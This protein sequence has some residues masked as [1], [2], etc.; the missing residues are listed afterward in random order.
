[1]ELLNQGAII[2]ILLVAG[3]LALV[4]GFAILTRYR[5][6]IQREMRRVSVAEHASNDNNARRQ[7]SAQL[8]YRVENLDPTL[9]GPH[10]PGAPA[11]P[12]PSL[13]CGAIYAAAGIAFGI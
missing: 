13:R 11:L 7:P 8:T 2:F 3:A 10:R 9:G 12:D 6:A 5:R 1:M 4:F